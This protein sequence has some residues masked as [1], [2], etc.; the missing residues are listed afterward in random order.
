M[1][2]VLVLV[3]AVVLAIGLIFVGCKP[4][5]IV[6]TV[7]ET[8]TETVTETVVETV[9][10]TVTETVVETVVETVYPEHWFEV[11]KTLPDRY[12]GVTL[13]VITENSK[14]FKDF[15]EVSKQFEEAT[16]INLEF[17]EL[18]YGDHY[19]KMMLSF[20]AGD[21]QYDVHVG[22]YTWFYDM[23]PYMADLEELATMVPDAPALPLDDY[24]QGVKDT[25]S[26]YN[27]RMIAIPIQCGIVFTTW[28]TEMYAELGLPEEGPNTWEEIYE[29]GKLIQ[30]PP[31]R[32]GF[33]MTGGNNIQVQVLYVQLLNYFGGEYYDAD[34]YPLFD[35][36]ESVEAIRFMAE[37]LTEISPP[38]ANTWGWQQGFQGFA[39]GQ[40]GQGIQWDGG[41]GGYDDPGSS[42]IVGNWDFKPIPGGTILGGWSKLVS[43]NSPNIEAAYL[44]VSWFSQ[45]EV[46]HALALSPLG[47]PPS[48]TSVQD[49]PTITADYPHVAL[50]AESLE[51]AFGFPG[52][53][54]V[55]IE[56][57][58][59]AE[60]NAAIVGEI[61]PEEAA[62][63]IQS[64]VVELLQ[65]RGVI[66]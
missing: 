39:S 16:G 12:A 13:N 22:T 32:Y 9:V 19:D 38:D 14:P 46:V 28:N 37:N 4:E 42:E 17:D 41:L 44:Y 6:E 43:A 2:R 5:T 56:L 8:V 59:D 57:I 62:A 65:E 63:N 53:L 27:G 52:P 58:M 11:T 21:E 54:F 29:Y 36:A 64:Q 50:M 60:C 33:A 61:T 15:I 35:S 26:N 7:V 20:M 45:R 10:E 48:L 25:Y 31:D 18:P 24:A 55:P 51:G 66:E 34:G 1:K 30:D 49:D 40:C 23:D 3:I 47:N